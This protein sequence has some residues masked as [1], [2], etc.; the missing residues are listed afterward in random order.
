MNHII[1]REHKVILNSDQV[2]D[3]Y[4]C[5]AT[6]IQRTEMKETN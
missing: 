3:K 4:Q 5:N 1:E 6:V 2:P